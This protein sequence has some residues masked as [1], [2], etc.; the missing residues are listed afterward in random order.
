MP[1]LSI[2]IVS[3]N[4]AEVT[5]ACIQSILAAQQLHPID[6][7]ILVVDNA[8]TD[9]SVDKIRSLKSRVI[10]VIP[11]K[12]NL[13]FGKANNVALSS[14]KG[15]YILF[16]NSDTIVSAIN[17]PALLEYMDRH[18]SVGILTVRVL[19]PTG[20]LDPA[21]HRGFPT[22][23]RS[24]TYF[25]KL[26]ALTRSIPF[27]NKLFGGYHLTHLNQAREHEI[28]S[29]SGAFFLTR[30]A[31]LDRIGGFD[32]SFFMYGEDL[33]LA[34]RI[35]EQGYTVVFYPHQSITHL[36]GVSGI[37]HA[38]KKRSTATT[39]YFYDAMRIFYDKHYARNYP[40][41]I[42]RFIHWVIA[43]KSKHS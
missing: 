34:K 40:P 23:W 38:N 1:R 11:Q 8:S 33:D 17:F 37:K 12:A 19:L 24:F 25:S 16:L 5:T 20:E 42:N 36:K 29:P 28:D 7:E 35:K 26:E 6:L 39:S 3:Y 14:A 18:S 31:I 27:I 4:T 32:E 9:D 13:G 43:S 10:R 30:K 22:V 21:S 41:V 2:I 15:S